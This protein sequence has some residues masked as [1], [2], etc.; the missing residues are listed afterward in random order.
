MGLPVAG[1]Q[2]PIQPLSPFPSSTGWFFSPQ[3]PQ[4][5]TEPSSLHNICPLATLLIPAIAPS[6]EILQLEQLSK[7]TATPRKGRRNL[8]W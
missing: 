3:T 2:T 7:R 6:D 1:C 8:G 4:A 5:N